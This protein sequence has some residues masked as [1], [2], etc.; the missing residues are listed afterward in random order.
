MAIF[1]TLAYISYQT[2]YGIIT[3]WGHFIYYQAFQMARGA[4]QQ[5]LGSLSSLYEGDL[6]LSDFSALLKMQP[7][8]VEPRHPLPFPRPFQKGIVFE[9][10][11][12]AIVWPWRTSAF[13]SLQGRW[14]LW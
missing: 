3:F 8:V 9:Q 14:L 4:F 6:F 13:R 12:H 5:M 11:K 7:K 2:V 1:G 10:V